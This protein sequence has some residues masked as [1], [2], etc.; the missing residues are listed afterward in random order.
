[1]LEFE[2]VAFDGVDHVLDTDLVRVVDAD[3]LKDAHPADLDIP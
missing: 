2:Q 3:R 1:M